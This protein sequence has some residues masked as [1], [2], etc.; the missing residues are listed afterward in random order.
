MLECGKTISQNWRNMANSF[1]P[2][3][4]GSTL[5]QSLLQVSFFPPAFTEPGTHKLIIWW[6]R[7]CEWW[8]I[9][10]MNI[11]VISKI[12]LF[13][14]FRNINKKNPFSVTYYFYNFFFFFWR[15][16]NHCKPR[17]QGSLGWR[18]CKTVLPGNWTSF[19]TVSVVQNE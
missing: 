7:R 13:L 16:Q 11:Q 12:F 2:Q 3:S 5:D 6:G 4:W 8:F 10:R 9:T 14:G 19:R 18:V 1:L 17:I 15:N